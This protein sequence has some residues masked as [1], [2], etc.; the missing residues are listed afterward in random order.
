[1]CLLF[2]P[3]GF[4]VPLMPTLVDEPP[5]TEG[6]IHEVKHDGYRTILAVYGASTRAF[7]PEGPA[8]SS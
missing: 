7:T 5:T 2:S 8:I 1:L 3:P 4:I 6:W